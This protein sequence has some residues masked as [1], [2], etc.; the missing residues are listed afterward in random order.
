MTQNTDPSTLTHFGA[1]PSERALPWQWLSGHFLPPAAALL[2]PPPSLCFL[3]ALP[4]EGA[5]ERLV[6]AAPVPAVAA[7]AGTRGIAA[8]RRERWLRA[9]RR[10]SC[11]ADA[12][13]DGDEAARREAPGPGGGGGGRGVWGSGGGGGDDEEEEGTMTRGRKEESL[14]STHR[15]RSDPLAP[16]RRAPRRFEGLFTLPGG[17]SPYS[18]RPQRLPRPPGESG[19]A[20]LERDQDGSHTKQTNRTASD[21]G[22]APGCCCPS[23]ARQVQG[24]TRSPRRPTA[25]ASPGGRSSSLLS[26]GTIVGGGVSRPCFGGGAKKRNL[27]RG[28]LPRAGTNVRGGLEPSRSSS[29]SPIAALGGDWSFL[30]GGTGGPEAGRPGRPGRLRVPAPR[31]APARP[32]AVPDRPRRAQ[33][34]PAVAPVARVPRCVRVFPA[35]GGKA[36]SS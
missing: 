26:T 25:A 20:P 11:R 36:P 2:R 15:P 6:G 21:G 24:L 22:S 34:P 28:G 5:E 13:R 4:P 18:R 35:G 19:T 9:P 7:G 31:K 14:R 33:R 27:L 12:D 29:R 10:G 16:P 3:L 32:P 1:N 17:G 23:P 30:G 8:P